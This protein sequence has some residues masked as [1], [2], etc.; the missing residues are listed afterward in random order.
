MNVAASLHRSRA[1]RM[2]LAAACVLF[3]ASLASAAMPAGAQALSLVQQIELPKVTGRIDHMDIDLVGNRL[4]VAALASNTVEIV[5]LNSGRDVESVPRMREPQ[6][7]VHL[8]SSHR[9]VVANGE[10]GDVQLFSDAGPHAAPTATAHDLEDADNMRFEPQ[11]NRLYVGYAHA[12][13]ILDPDTLRL[14]KSVPLSGHPEAFEIEHDGVR[15]FVNVPGTGHIAV[16]DRREGKV[17]QTWNVGGAFSNFPM[18]LDEADHRLFI[19]TRLP[20][21]LMAFDTTS[22]KRVA[23]MP[24][25]GDADD[26][27]YDAAHKRIYAVCGEGAVDVVR[28]MSAD[29]YDLVEHVATAP[30]ARTGLFVPSLSMLLVAAPARDGVAEIRAYKIK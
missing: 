8:A 26:L 3:A 23:D 11:E 21:R 14:L 17:V 27:F 2:H 12:L 4:F 28:Q 18:A 6:G 13:A 7:V 5:D 15:V 24:L 1:R 9:F 19:A 20:A 30:G 10:G 29:R 25:C 16:V 22:G